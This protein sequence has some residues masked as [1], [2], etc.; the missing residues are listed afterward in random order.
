MPS[1]SSRARVG[2]A[3]RAAVTCAALTWC[4]CAFALNAT[5]DVN[6][7]AHSAWKLRDGFAKGTITC[8]TQTR[9]GYLW[10]GTELGLLRF[11]GVRTTPWQSP[12][13]QPLPSNVILGL[14]AA[15][16]GTLWI[17]TDQGLASWKD[18]QL[19]R[20]DA[21]AGDYVGKLLEDREGAIWMV[22]FKSRWTLCRTQQ[23]AVTCYGDDG[24]PGA[25]AIGVHEDRAGNLWV[26]TLNCGGG[27][28]ALEPSTRFPESPTASR[29]SL[30]APMVRC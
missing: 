14:L 21:L 20:Y 12:S 17:A 29:A 26:G 19:R 24:G 25:N 10:F 16:D 9:D 6:Q 30:T 18:G 2:V 3:L 22:R 15:R 28:L 13:N 5:L 4:P 7:Y 1:G 8:V 11:D 23:G 27:H